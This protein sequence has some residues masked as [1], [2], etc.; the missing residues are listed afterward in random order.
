MGGSQ[1]CRTGQLSYFGRVFALA[2]RLA[3]DDGKGR[4]LSEFVDEA[5][6]ILASATDLPS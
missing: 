4:P 3:L 2:A 1:S 5:K 6:R